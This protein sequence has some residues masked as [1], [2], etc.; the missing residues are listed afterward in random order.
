[1]GYDG[2]SMNTTVMATYAPP[3]GFGQLKGMANLQCAMEE[4]VALA[5]VAIEMGTHFQ[6][7]AQDANTGLQAYKN[8]VH[9]TV[10]NYYDTDVNGGTHFDGIVPA[11]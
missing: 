9:A 11:S 7:F 6:Q 5:T 10:Q 2:Y 4:M 3:A 8:Q 1:M